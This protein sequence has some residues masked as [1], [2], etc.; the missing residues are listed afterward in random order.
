MRMNVNAR[1]VAVLGLAGLLTFGLGPAGAAT[2]SG[3]A[4][5]PNDTAPPLLQLEVSASRVVEG[6]SF[7]V[8]GNLGFA[9]PHELVIELVLGGEA[10]VKDL[11]PAA[12][13][14]VFAKGETYASVILTAV[15][16]GQQELLENLVLTVDDPR[17]ELA[18]K[19]TIEIDEAVTVFTTAG[20]PVGTMTPCSENP[21]RSIATDTKGIVEGGAAA[22]VTMT[23]AE[24]GCSDLSYPVRVGGD[25]DPSELVV[26]PGSFVFPMGA[27]S[28]SI[29][30]SAVNDASDEPI[31][32]IELWPVATSGGDLETGVFL[33]LLDDDAD[34]A[35][36]NLSGPPR[37]VAGERVQFQIA[38]INPGHKELSSV[39]LVETPMAGLIDVEWL[40]FGK[41]GAECP[42]KGVG[43]V[44]LSASM[45]AFSAI[46]VLVDGQVSP[47]QRDALN[48]QASV[49]IVD[50]VLSDPNPGDNSAFATHAVE[51]VAD[52]ALELAVGPWDPW[53]AEPTLTYTATVRNLGPS[54]ASGAELTSPLAAHLA[55]S[56]G[57]PDCLATPES[58]SCTVGALAAGQSIG[59]DLVL[60]VLDPYPTYTLQEAWLS[61]SDPDPSPKNDEAF[62]DTKLDIVAPTIE[63]IVALGD[64]SN[65]I[66]GACSQLVETPVRL[67][68]RFDEPMVV[69]DVDV[70]DDFR[71]YRPGA[72][73]DFEF[74]SCAD[75]GFA[76][77]VTDD[78][79]V[80]ILGAEWNEEATAVELSLRQTRAIDVPGPYRLLVCGSLS[81]RGD[82]PLDGDGDGT[83]GDDAIVGYRVDAGNLVRNGHFDCDLA[84]WTAVAPTLED[85]TLG[86]D[87]SGSSISRSARI[88]NSAA[89]PSVGAGQ[90]VETGGASL[91]SLELRHRISPV[92]PDKGGEIVSGEL[93]ETSVD[94][95]CSF[96]AATSCT[97]A[98][99]GAT[100]VELPS[101]RTA[102]TGSS[103]STY[104]V[105]LAVPEGAQSVLCTVAATGELLPFVLEI[106]QVRMLAVEWGPTAGPVD[107]IGG[108]AASFD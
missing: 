45:P 35:L 101:G 55:W 27:T 61:P 21:K 12:P 49:T 22:T 84:G 48:H 96:Y 79:E 70:R 73:G 88:D 1:R 40:C 34:I 59:L 82:N 102:P 58:V 71:L 50:G 67:T 57:D 86:T 2:G 103:W 42:E 65:T 15:E 39:R 81:D 63:E 91:M 51:V 24:S 46:V 8:E 37:L 11:A 36:A 106:D 9:A 97:D 17:V 53:A 47:A 100:G 68:V 77:P 6:E 93:V 16:D 26:S 60:S 80:Q 23:L 32:S 89:W 31:E 30:V 54:D 3:P 72:D 64:R 5:P 75:A 41:S 108:G 62:L 43:F 4:V 44:D 18:R 29:T 13:A 105:K 76:L 56:G 83:G 10:S 28:A 52:L 74:D 25:A 107:E 98:L 66:L 20:S 104:G 38:V 90:C 7:Q 92:V 19:A 85:W 78:I 95:A 14:L 33:T 99:A 69:A 94:V 87:A